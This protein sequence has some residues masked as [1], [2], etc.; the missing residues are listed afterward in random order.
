M[1]HN[2]QSW[3]NL[4]NLVHV[5]FCQWGLSEERVA[6]ESSA[7]LG[8]NLWNVKYSAQHSLPQFHFQH[9]PSYPMFAMFS[10]SSW[11]KTLI[12]S[13]K[14]FQDVSIFM[15]QDRNSGPMICGQL[16]LE[17]NHCKFLMSS[18][19][20]QYNDGTWGFCQTSQWLWNRNSMLIS[21]ACDMLI[22]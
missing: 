9:L 21:T 15:I 6:N 13:T 20:R 19:S 5:E 10:L 17:I 18:W 1:Q 16:L 8:P 4:Q 12:K 22:P 3:N 11:L 14:T 2:L 7:G